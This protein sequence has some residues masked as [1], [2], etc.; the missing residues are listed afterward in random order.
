MLQKKV[1]Q[2]FTICHY[3]S[4][5]WVTLILIFAEAIWFPFH[6]I[7]FASQDC[8]ITQTFCFITSHTKLHS[9]KER[10]NESILLVCQ[11]L[12]NTI[13]YR[14]TTLFQFDNRH[15]NTI[16]IDYEVWSLFLTINYCNFFCDC[17]IIISRCF[18]IHEVNSLRCSVICFLYLCTIF[19]KRINLMICIIQ[20]MCHII[21]SFSQFSNSAINQLLTVTAKAQIRTKTV[22]TDILIC[23]IF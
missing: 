1:V 3:T 6:I 5:F 19:Q 23:N 11:I 9:C 20:A 16:H 4:I 12:S 15:C 13:R 10:C 17:K 18:N 7:F 2:S 22:F 14:N 21:G 8:S